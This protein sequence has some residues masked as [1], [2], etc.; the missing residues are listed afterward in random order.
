[1][2]TEGVAPEAV[3][4]NAA[5]LVTTRLAATIMPGAANRAVAADGRLDVLAGQ[6]GV[7]TGIRLGDRALGRH[8]DHVEPGLSLGHPDPLVN[9]AIQILSC[10]GNTVTLLDGPA[11]G[12]EGMVYGKHGTTLA[13]LPQDGLALAAP[14]E[15]VA[16]EACGAG[17]AFEDEPDV[18]CL[19]LSPALAEAWAKR[20]PDGRIALTV[21]AI[22]PSEA[23]AAGIGMPSQRF[24]MDLH[25]DQPPMAAL[26]RDLGFGDLVAVEDQDHRFGRRH[27]PGWLMVGVISHGRTIAGGHGLG[28]MTLLTGP[29][30]RFRLVPSR[31]A[32]VARLMNRWGEL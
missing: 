12:T 5:R 19:S 18:T 7:V 4:T 22:L 10:V 6:G 8:G 16:I 30:E 9:R 24:N 11:K 25:S 31:E 3:A 27:R 1:M 29:A 17:L 13:A 20:D 26:C 23:A 21:A 14:G 28:L 32:N 2:A 15:R